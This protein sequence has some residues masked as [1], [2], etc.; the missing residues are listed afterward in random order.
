MNVQNFRNM[1]NYVSCV[2]T[3]LKL[4]AKGL[5][6]YAI[7]I[8]KSLVRYK[9]VYKQ[10]KF[11][12]LKL[13]VH[14]FHCLDEVLRI[15]EWNET[16]AFRFIRSFVANDFCFLKARIFSEYTYQHLICNVVSE[17]ATEDSKI[18]WKREQN[19]L[20]IF[21]WFEE[22]AKTKMSIIRL[23]L[24]ILERIQAPVSISWDFSFL[25]TFPHIEFR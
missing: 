16:K 14:L 10:R 15:L 19:W 9:I 7:V 17:I 23:R 24:K 12:Y 8:V 18:V 2:G 22:R 4:N 3:S 6:T 11:K 21:C 1:K 25:G 5:K 13:T 20:P